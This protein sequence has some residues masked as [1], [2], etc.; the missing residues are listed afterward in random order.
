MSRP[1]FTDEEWEEL[2]KKIKPQ[3]LTK[4]EIINAAIEMMKDRYKTNQQRIENSEY[5]EIIAL[6][7]KY[8]W[9]TGK[10]LN[11]QATAEHTAKMFNKIAD[12]FR[13]NKLFNHSRTQ[14]LAWGGNPATLKIVLPKD[15]IVIDDYP[16]HV[17]Y[18][19][20]KDGYVWMYNGNGWVKQEKI[21]MTR[22]EAIEKFNKACDSEYGFDSKMIAA[23]EALGL[24]KFDEEKSLQQALDESGYRITAEIL[25]RELNKRGYKIVKK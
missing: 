1:Y 23:F 2:L 12:E 5:A 20:N 25:E 22:K 10:K 18:R 13:G 3:T 7:P 16:I 9:M 19:H 6:Q 11:Q 8:E 4:E 21:K 14:H 15:Y 17:G 24:I